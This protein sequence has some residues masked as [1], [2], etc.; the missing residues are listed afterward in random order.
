M[1]AVQKTGVWCMH[2]VDTRKLLRVLRK[3]YP[4]SLS[5]SG[6]ARDSESVLS[7]KIAMKPLDFFH[8]S[9]IIQVVRPCLNHSTRDLVPRNLERARKNTHSCSHL[10]TFNKQRLS[11]QKTSSFFH[12]PMGCLAWSENPWLRFVSAAGELH[13]HL[14]LKSCLVNVS[15]ND[16][17][18]RTIYPK[19]CLLHIPSLK[20]TAKST[21]KLKKWNTIVSFWKGRKFQGPCWFQGV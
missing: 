17:I 6:S 18:P 9:G 10:H 7:P 20:L 14:P 4:I 1:T 12:V 21:W 16:R 13:Q 11:H 2:M 19:V 5:K 15:V 3:F 8:K